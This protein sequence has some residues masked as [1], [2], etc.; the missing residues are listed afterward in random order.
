[1]TAMSQ[2]HRHLLRV[3]L[4]GVGHG[5]CVMEG[6]PA[7][8][9]RL[10][11][12]LVK[13]LLERCSKPSTTCRRKASPYWL[14][15]PLPMITNTATSSHERTLDTRVMTTTRIR[16][17]NGGRAGCYPPPPGKQLSVASAQIEA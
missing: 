2:T 9:D 17:P 11:V 8:I 14:Q 1:M 7:P 16:T 4:F 10:D 3:T 12:T 15:C 6:D 13:C 5:R